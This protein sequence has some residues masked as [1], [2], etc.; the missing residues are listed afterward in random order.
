MT[1]SFKKYTHCQHCERNSLT[2]FYFHFCFFSFAGCYWRCSLVVERPNECDSSRA[3]GDAVDNSSER[4][5]SNSRSI[6]SRGSKRKFSSASSISIHEEEDEQDPSDNEKLKRRRLSATGSSCSSSSSVTS[7]G[8]LQSPRPRANS[9]NP[10]LQSVD[11][12][13]SRSTSPHRHSSRSLVNPIG[14]GL[15]S[16]SQL[17]GEIEKSSATPS[18]TLSGL[19]FGPEE[20]RRMFTI[21]YA[22][23]KQRRIR[24]CEAIP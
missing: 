18:S 11:D 20:Q 4:S 17:T 9:T 23:Y 2:H 13:E 19:F 24:D 16:R 5:S 3:T 7:D 6:D 15:P 14:R 21:P 1:L 12:Q 22:S 10:V 8:S